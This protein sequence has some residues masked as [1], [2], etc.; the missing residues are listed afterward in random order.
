MIEP[1]G[2][3]GCSGGEGSA[4]DHDSFPDEAL[5]VPRRGLAAGSWRAWPLSEH[6]LLPWGPHAV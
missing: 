3:H 5:D 1:H 6:L 4:D 2:G